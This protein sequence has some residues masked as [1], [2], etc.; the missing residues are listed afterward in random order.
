MFDIT[1][2]SFVQIVLGGVL[3]YVGLIILLRVSK[4]R[5]L[6]QLNMFDFVITI[7]FG[8]AMASVI[9]S[10]SVSLLE[11]LLG[12]A[13]L[14]FSQFIVTFISFRSD[15][16]TSLI[17][18]EPKLLYS[19]GQYYRDAMK[20]ERVKEVEILQSIR[21]Q[22]IGSLDEVKA[23]VLETDGSMS[24]IK[25]KVGDTLSNVKKPSS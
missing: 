11:G 12:F 15:K 3:A 1:W 16:F 6:S 9:L 4:K 5:T 19:E 14:I 23:V 8:S 25:K 22:G 18:A 2:D 24:I 17:K 7:A 10:S 21:K 20:S 13:V